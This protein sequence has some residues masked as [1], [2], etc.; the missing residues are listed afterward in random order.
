LVP[1]ASYRRLATLEARLADLT[2][3]AG[4]SWLDLAALSDGELLALATWRDKCEEAGGPLPL[5]AELQT[6]ERRMITDPALAEVR[7]RAGWFMAGRE[8]GQVWRAL[9]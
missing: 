9:V 3:T 6:I 1:K 2:E 5:P 8:M 4:E 7:Q